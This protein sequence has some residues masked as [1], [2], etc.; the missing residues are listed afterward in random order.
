MIPFYMCCSVLELPAQ[1]S[2][3]GGWSLPAPDGLF[4][5]P[6]GLFL[7]GTSSELQ[8]HRVMLL[9][10]S[11]STLCPPSSPYGGL[12]SPELG[13][14]CLQVALRLPAVSSAER[15]STRGAAEESLQ[16]ALCAC[17][18]FQPSQLPPNPSEELNSTSCSWEENHSGTRSSVRPG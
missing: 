1:A 5:L 13:V 9:M 6:D 16:A 2:C 3:T 11:L 15:S 17:S 18:S 8:G 12:L 14:F 10:L 4:L 7:L